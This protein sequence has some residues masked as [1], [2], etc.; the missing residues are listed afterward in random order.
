MAVAFKHHPRSQQTYEPPLIA[1]E[2]AFLGDV[3]SSDSY[4]PEK[5]ISAGFYRLEKGTP[6]VYEYTFDEMKII[7]E[8]KFEISDE[9]GQ[10]V[11]AFPGDVFHFPKGSKVTFTTPSYG[12]AFFTGQRAKTA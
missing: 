11:E 3:D 9:T 8:G 5:P 2:N 6:L 4:N 10:K 12:L 1:N 7:L